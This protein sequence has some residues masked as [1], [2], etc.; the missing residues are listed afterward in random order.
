[1]GRAAAPAFLATGTGLMEDNFFPWTGAVGLRGWG[2][3]HVS[4]GNTSDGER[5]RG[6][7]EDL[8]SSPTTHPLWWA[9]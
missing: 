1:M 2:G 5:W 9:S 6:T 8:I 4:G 7:D 3:K